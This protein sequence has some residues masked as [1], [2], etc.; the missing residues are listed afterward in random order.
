MTGVNY[1]NYRN[2]G[3]VG[4]KLNA[5]CLFNAAHVM[6]ASSI[7]T[8]LK[9]QVAEVE[10]S[11]LPYA[12]YWT[13]RANTIKD[14]KEECFDLWRIVSKYPP[15]IGLWL[16]IDFTQGVTTNNSLLDRYYKYIYKWGLKDKCGLYCTRTQL[17]KISWNSYCNKFCLWL[18]D[19]SAGI[20]ELGKLLTP[21][22]FKM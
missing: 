19:H 11:H 4:V 18:I 14:V 6:M 3:V 16:N 9:Q 22:Y 17:G 20:N 21:N 5:G 8:S 15:K 1:S 7:N 12:L 13:A 2:V 10:A